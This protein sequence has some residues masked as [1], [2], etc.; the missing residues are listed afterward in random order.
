MTIASAIRNWAAT[1]ARLAREP[2][3]VSAVETA[4]LLPLFLA[5]LLGIVEFSRALWTQAA[6]QYAVEAAAR[7]A[8]VN[9]TTCDN[10]ADTKTFAATQAYGMTVASSNFSVTTPSCGNQ[11]SVSY[12]F[13]FIVPQLVPGNLTLSAKSCHP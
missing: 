8:A 7:C 6:L 10:A 13:P 12:A 1:L 5:L 3:G 2:L 11:V 9:T 4:L